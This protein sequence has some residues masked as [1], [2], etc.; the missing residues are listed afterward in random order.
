VQ[1]A[2]FDFA[3]AG[4]TVIAIATTAAQAILQIMFVP[5]MNSGVIADYEERRLPVPVPS[6][7]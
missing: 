6:N 3:A 1:P 4:A 7:G 5:Q 2:I